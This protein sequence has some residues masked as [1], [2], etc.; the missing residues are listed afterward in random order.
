VLRSLSISPSSWYYRP[1]S[2]VDDRRRRWGVAVP[3]AVEQAVVEMAT[4][5]P[6][7]GY[8][9]I[10]VMCRRAGGWVTDRQAYWVMRAHGLLQRRRQVRAAAVYQAAR[11]FELLPT[12]PNDLWQTDVTYVHIPGHGWWYGVAVIDY[13]SRYVLALRLTPSY[14]AAA[15][16]EVLKAARDRAESIHGPLSGAVFLVTDNGPSFIARAFARYAE[17]L[18]TRVR[19]QYRTPAQLGL[20]ERT[21]GTLKKEEVY[22][23]IYDGPAHAR[24]CLAQFERRDNHSRPHWALRPLDGGDPFVPADV[25]VNGHPIQIPK[26]QPWAVAARQQLDDLIAEVTS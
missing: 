8:K 26:W 23:R 14:S 21:S 15:V 20:L 11:L 3:E 18:F 12:A 22:W 9:R 7:Y 24:D 10:A 25:Y 6:W 19:I 5:N 13:Y 1:K 17:G 2:P 16:V 4:G